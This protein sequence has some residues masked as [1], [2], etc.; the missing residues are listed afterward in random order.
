MTPLPANT[1]T[2]LDVRFNRPYTTGTELEYI[3][4]A[5][6]GAHLSGNGPF[7]RRCAEWLE[8]RLGAERALLT[9]SC[10]G[11]LEIA[12]LLTEI[13]PGDEV[14]LPSFTFTS[15]ATAFALRGARLVFVD[16]REDTLNLDESLVEDAVTDQTRVLVAVHYAG[17][18]CQMDKLLEIAKRHGLVLIED[19]AQALGS[20]FQ[21]EP[22]GTLGA[23]GALSFHETKNII[24]G[25]GGALLA[26]NA[27]LVERAEVIQEKGTNRQAFFRG[28]VEK[29]SW[30]DIG[31]SFAAS[32]LVA[33]FLWAQLE[34]ADWLI[35]QRLAIWNAY[36]T[37]LSDLEA[38]GLLRRPVVPDEVVHNG[39][40]YYVL[41]PSEE[42]RDLTLD[43]LAREGVQTVFHYVPLHSSPAGLRYGKRAGDLPITERTSATL[44]RLPIWVGLSDEK[45]S[46]VIAALHRVL[47]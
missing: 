23:L 29:Y 41:L 34:A 40:L 12:A 33:A 43:A 19:A 8:Q 37:G 46:H 36:H 30:I 2:A 22:L 27:G 35:E 9:H 10:T 28:Q 1:R 44:L 7:T 14:I 20:S 4:E 32:E 16:I 45:I 31:S 17:V 42:R 11:A 18:S 24:S 15:T 13:Q 21:G 26:N 39:H 6:E 3:K 25:E 47:S 38:A 5:I